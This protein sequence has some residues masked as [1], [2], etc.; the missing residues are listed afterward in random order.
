MKRTTIEIWVGIF[1][2]IGL[3]CV[4]YLTIKLGKMELIGGNHYTVSARFLSVSG[5][6]TGAEVV[7]AGVQVGSVDR[8]TLD[9]ERM[10]ALVDLKIKN[11]IELTEDVIASVKTAGLIGDKYIRLSPGGAEEVLKPGDL[12]TET[13]SAIDLEDMIGKYVFG[14]V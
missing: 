3:I 12:I 14:D 1:V 10:M 6:K 9:Q 5:L 2:L 11:G 8:I 13:E 7:L 4:G